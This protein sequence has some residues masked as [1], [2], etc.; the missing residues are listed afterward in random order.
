MK[1]STTDSKKAIWAVPQ[2]QILQLP[3]TASGEGVGKESEGGGAFG[4]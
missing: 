3:E 2:I 4:S 1:P